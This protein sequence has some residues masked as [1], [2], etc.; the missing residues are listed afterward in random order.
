METFLKCSTNSGVRGGRLQTQPALSSTAALDPEPA[1]GGLQ[2]QGGQTDR[3]MIT[4]RVEASVICRWPGPSPP[5]GLL[6]GY[7]G[8][9]AGQTY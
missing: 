3:Q 1:T 9:A 8:A 5:R 4:Y 6:H 2:T 7:V